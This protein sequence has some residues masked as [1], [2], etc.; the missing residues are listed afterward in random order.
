M[1]KFIFLIC[2]T[3][4]FGFSQQNILID[5]VGYPNEPSIVINPNNTNQLVAGS[6]IN[7]VY[8]SNDAGLTWTKNALN[9]TYGVWGDPTLICDNSNNF[10]FFHLSNPTPDF[11]NWIDRIVCQKS[12]NTGLS[13]SSGTFAG[14]NGTKDQDKQW[15]IF[16]STT[17]NIYLTWT[18]FDSYGSSNIANKSRIRFS[19]STD[20]GSTWSPAI[21]INTIDG[22][23][24]DDSSTVEGAVPTVGPSGQLYVSWSGPNGLVFKKSLDHGVTWPTNETL[25]TTTTGWD[26]SISGIDRSNGL[27]ITSCDRS[28]GPNNGTIYINWS[29]QTNGTQDT[30]VFLSKSTNGGATWSAPLRVNDDLPGKQQFFSWMTI[31]QTNGYIYIVFYDRRNHDDD[32]TDVYLAHSTNGGTTFTNTKIS[33]TPFFPNDTVFFGDY[34]NITAHNGIIRP[35][36]ARMDG[37]ETSIWTA[38]ISQASLANKEYDKDDST[39]SN[40]PNPSYEDS[41]FSFKLAQDSPISIKI[42]DLNGKEVY[43]LIEDKIFSVGKHVLSM[44]SNLLAKGEYLYTIKSNYFI[45]SKKMIVR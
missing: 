17:N 25:V 44:K 31:D 22:T 33:T 24:I 7:N 30:D 10:Y 15:A 37:G 36:W 34:T 32:Q 39:V 16:D 40:Y 29:D 38:L 41:F 43:T 9:S 3:T 35:I 27:P 42:Y 20:A 6:N 23:C 19:K 26:Y 11:T 21:K 18:E 1:K 13:W 8:R 5:D 28:G 2:L 45:K 4:S 12:T 14:L